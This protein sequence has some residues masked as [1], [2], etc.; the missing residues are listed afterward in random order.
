MASVLVEPDRP[1]GTGVLVLAGS[2]G[3]VD[4][5]RARL[6]ARE[7]ALVMSIRWF[8]GAGQRPGPFEVPLETFVSAL[9]RLQP[10]CDRLSIVGT[11][12][13]AEAALLTAAHDD[14]VAACAAFAPSSV[15]WAGVDGAR[16]TSHWTL[17]G[18][19]LPF[20]PFVGDWVPDSDPPAYRSLYERSLAADPAVSAA[21]TIPVEHIRGSVLL[22]AGGD[23]QVWPAVTFAEQVAE[24]RAAHGLATEVVTHPGAGHRTVLPG[25]EPVVGGQRMARGGSTAADAELG[26]MCWPSLVR[27]LG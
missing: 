13:G 9:D 2:S 20:V 1:S 3:R 23:D 21:A 11:S 5:Q 15:V 24:R 7:G 26:E 22:V 8:G 25:E 19:P 6:L 4:E 18:V 27:L 17:G 12:F 10:R 14:R 16:Q